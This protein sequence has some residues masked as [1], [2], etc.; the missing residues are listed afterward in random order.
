[1]GKER[2]MGNVG[3]AFFGTDDADDKVCF[4]PPVLAHPALR[5]YAQDAKDPSTIWRNC[6]AGEGR[7]AYG[8]DG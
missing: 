4:E 7:Q 5:G 8:Q 1:M 2:I 3:T 6:G